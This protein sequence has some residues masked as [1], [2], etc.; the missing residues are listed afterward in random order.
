MPSSSPILGVLVCAALLCSSAF[1]FAASAQEIPPYRG[2]ITDLAELVSPEKEAELHGLMES[3]RNGDGGHEIAVLTVPSLG[4]RSLEDFSLR[5]AREWGLGKVDTSNGA[6]LVIA[7][8]ERKTRIEVGRGLEGP[9]PDAIAGRILRNV[10]RPGMRSGDYDRAIEDTVRALHAAAGGDYGPLERAGDGSS[11]STKD[12]VIVAGMVIFFLV[13]THRR[14][15]GPKGLRGG[16]R[17]GGGG[18]GPIVI[19]SPGRYSGGSG[20]GFGGF[21]GGGGFSGGGASGGW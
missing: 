3:Y 10:L 14:R 16:R 15:R 11:G 1:G 12:L 17:R 9:I 19:G 2:W 13:V 20:G 8:A 6:L 4:G 21:G 18:F 5:V 7:V